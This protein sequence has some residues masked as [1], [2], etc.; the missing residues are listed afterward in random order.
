MYSGKIKIADNTHN[1]TIAVFDGNTNVTLKANVEGDDVLI[2][3]KS[4][5]NIGELK[6]A[7][8]MIIKSLNSMVR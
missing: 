5:E 3:G 4:I 6:V 2:N 1:N 7:L 8:N